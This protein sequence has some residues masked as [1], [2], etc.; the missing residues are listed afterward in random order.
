MNSAAG[1]LA[2]VRRYAAGDG[3]DVKKL[4]GRSGE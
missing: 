1:I 4:Q 3:G 2:A